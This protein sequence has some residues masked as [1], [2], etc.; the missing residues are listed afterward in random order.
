MSEMGQRLVS[1]T[2]SI[3]LRQRI[4]SVFSQPGFAHLFDIAAYQRLASHTNPISL[5][6]RILSGFSRPTWPVPLFAFRI[7][8]THWPSGVNFHFLFTFSLSLILQCP[9]LSLKA[10]NCSNF[11]SQSLSDQVLIVKLKPIA[12]NASI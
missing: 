4:Q 7:L 9:F 10:T 5:R 3:S 6:R 1:Q 2:K 12:S 8:S 11:A